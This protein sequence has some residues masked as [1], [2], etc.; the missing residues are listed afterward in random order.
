MKKKWP[1][2]LTFKRTV[3]ILIVL[4]AGIVLSSY[5]LGGYVGVKA[6]YDTR[7]FTLD[8]FV[9]YTEYEAKAKEDATI[10]PYEEDD[11]FAEK[12]EK[13]NYREQLQVVVNA[14]NAE[15][16]ALKASGGD[17]QEIADLEQLAKDAQMSITLRQVPSLEE[18]TAIYIEE[19]LG[20]GEKPL[21]ETGSYEF[22]FNTKW[23]TFK[24]VEKKTGN[25]WYSNPVDKNDENA[26]NAN[27]LRQ[28][29]S[30]INI[31]FAGLL[32]A[33]S[34]WDSFNYS[35]SDVDITGEEKLTPN[36]QI[37]KITDESGKV[38]ALQVYYT[39][40]KRGIDYAYFPEKF[41]HQKIC[42]IQELDITIDETLPELLR[43]IKK[44]QQMVNGK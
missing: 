4:I 9:P 19:A 32:G 1:K 36:F 28:Q 8:G 12:V 5:F 14:I 25:E 6:S 44:V 33:T 37:K 35:I 31:S 30:L 13:C 24:V 21:M 18:Y 43:E 34:E 26:I 10:I 39:F 7:D 17:P 42:S 22:W 29:Q 2:F 3:L 16:K 38:T 15:V 27:T 40:Q 20:F 11:T 41:S 23:T